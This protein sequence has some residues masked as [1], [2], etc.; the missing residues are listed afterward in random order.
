MAKRTMAVI[1]SIV[2]VLAGLPVFGNV[3]AKAAVSSDEFND[4]VFKYYIIDE[5]EKTVAILGFA[6]NRNYPTTNGLTL[7]K[8]PIPQRT[9]DQ[10]KS[11]PSSEKLA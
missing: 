9:P 11:N 2:L 7:P 5:D 10:R 4:D 6:E 3:E 8:K 1:L